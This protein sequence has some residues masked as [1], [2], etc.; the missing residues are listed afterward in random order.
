VFSRQWRREGHQLDDFLD[1]NRIRIGSLNLR[2]N[3]D[4]R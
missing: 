1:K 3:K 4:K 2:A